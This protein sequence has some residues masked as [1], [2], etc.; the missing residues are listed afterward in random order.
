[1]KN[2]TTTRLPEAK[3]DQGG[4]GGRPSTP[5]SPSLGTALDADLAKDLIE[6]KQCGQIPSEGNTNGLPRIVEITAIGRPWKT[7]LVCNIC[8]GI[9][10]G[11]TLEDAIAHW[12]AGWFPEYSYDLPQDCSDFVENV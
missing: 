12:Q 10:T 7:E 9:H 5:C 2:D 8:G 4:S 3:N 11:R 6:C 1:M